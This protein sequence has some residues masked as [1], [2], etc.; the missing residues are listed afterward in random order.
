MTPST[1]DRGS[2]ASYLELVNADGNNTPLIGKGKSAQNVV[3]SKKIRDKRY[4]SDA[5]LTEKRPKTEAA[6][7]LGPPARGGDVLRR[8]AEPAVT[9]AEETEEQIGN[10]LAIEP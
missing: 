3:D 9:A 6:S 8:S 5:R 2:R 4:E 1:P 7:R 10:A